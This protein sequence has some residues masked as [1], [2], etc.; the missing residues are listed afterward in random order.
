LKFE[1][2][3]NRKYYSPGKFPGWILNEGK[4]LHGKE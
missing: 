1:I 4:E 2:T 3:A